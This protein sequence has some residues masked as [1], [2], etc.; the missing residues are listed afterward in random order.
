MRDYLAKYDPMDPWPDND[1][2][3]ARV[4]NYMQTESIIASNLQQDMTLE[5]SL[6]Q[7]SVDDLKNLSKGVHI[8][9]TVRRSEQY[10][11]ET[12]TLF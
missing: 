5:E 6:Y 10:L 7:I 4:E 1:L 9:N 11:G 8:R 2:L 12:I 3:M